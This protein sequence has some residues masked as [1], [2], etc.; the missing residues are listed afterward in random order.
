MTWP[1]ILLVALGGSA[2]SVVRY[3]VGKALPVS[4]PS[5][6]PYA[7]FIV[8]IAGCLLIGLFY[9]LS[10]KQDWMTANMRLLLMTGF[11]G[12]FTTFSAFTL[13]GMNL[14]NTHQVVLFLIYFALSI[15][16]GLGATFFGYWLIAKG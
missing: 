5:S 3:L 9:G 1:Q 4:A 6:F 11:C 12:G 13:E 2:G 16:V 7:T 10:V 15:M 8:N 14:L